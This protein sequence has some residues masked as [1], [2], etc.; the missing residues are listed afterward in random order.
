MADTSGPTMSAIVSSTLKKS[1]KSNYPLSDQEVK[2]L[3]LV[4]DVFDT[5]SNG[6]I[7]RYELKR[8]MRSLGFKVTTKTLEVSTCTYS[9]NYIV[10]FNTVLGALSFCL[11]AIL[12]PCA[13]L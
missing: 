13:V 9:Y 5:D 11:Q 6:Y 8:A 10:P 3:K 1:E 2:D 4:F 7:D 12:R